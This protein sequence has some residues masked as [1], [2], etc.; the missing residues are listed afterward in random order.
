MSNTKKLTIA[1]IL[2]SVGVICS[3][4][5]IPIGVAKVFPIQ[6]FINVLA[7]VFLGPV[8]AVLMAFVTSLVRVLTGT[9]SFLSWEHVWSATMWVIVQVH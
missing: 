5:Y 9:G 3:A 7:G 6:H 8:Y 4:F 2:I 1:G